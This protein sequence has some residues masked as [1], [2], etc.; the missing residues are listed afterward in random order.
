MRFQFDISESYELV[1]NYRIS[2]YLPI[3]RHVPD[4]A[5]NILP[6]LGFMICIIVAS[7]LRGHLWDKENMVF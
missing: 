5:I 1:N 3:Y 2:V 6:H 7:V 4:I